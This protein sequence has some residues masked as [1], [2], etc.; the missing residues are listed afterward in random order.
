M[1]AN[2]INLGQARIHMAELKIPKS[3]SRLAEQRYPMRPHFWW[4]VHEKI[5]TLMA[6]T[7]L[8]ENGAHDKRT[9]WKTP[10]R[11]KAYAIQ[12]YLTR[13]DCV[14]DSIE[15]A[16]QRA[17]TWVDYLPTDPVE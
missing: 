12:K 14:F 10:T 15:R 2:T 5:Y 17:E 7:A 3:I 8:R 6:L 11:K 16:E 13:L 4:M 9:V 1:R